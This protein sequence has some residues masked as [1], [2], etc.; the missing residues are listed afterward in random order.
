MKAMMQIAKEVL[1]FW[2]VEHGQEQWFGGGPAFDAKLAARFAET[3]EAVSRGET[4]QWR[5]TPEGRLAEIVVLDQ[6]SRQLHRGTARAF[7]QDGM[8][9]VLAQE[10]VARGDDMLLP[11]GPQR[12]FLYMP[13]MHSESLLVHEETVRLFT[14]LGN[15][16]A[17]E[18]EMAHVTCLKRFGR[19]PRRNAPLGRTSTPEE[20]EYIASDQD[21]W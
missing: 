5:T 11:Q 8:A 7:A 6:F 1:E 18:F 14:L 4:W 21:R 12:M 9:L 20:I 13:Y 3:H 16:Q 2:F 17:L 19:Y 10:A 15:E